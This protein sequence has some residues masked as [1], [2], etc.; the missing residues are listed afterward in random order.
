[1]PRVFTLIGV[2]ELRVEYYSMNRLEAMI[3]TKRFVRTAC[4]IRIAILA[5]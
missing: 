5:L 1:M 3:G 2:S 4:V